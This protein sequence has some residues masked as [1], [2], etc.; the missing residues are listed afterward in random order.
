MFIFYLY[1]MT[2]FRHSVLWYEI[3]QC[4]LFY[5][6]VCATPNPAPNILSFLL[7]RKAWAGV[8]GV[9]LRWARRAGQHYDDSVSNLW[10]VRSKNIHWIRKKNNADPK[11]S[12][13]STLNSWTRYRSDNTSSF[14]VS[15]SDCSLFVIS[16]S[17][18]RHCEKSLILEQSRTTL[19][20]PSYWAKRNIPNKAC[21]R[22]FG[23]RPLN[24]IYN[25]DRLERDSSPTALNDFKNKSLLK[26]IAYSFFFAR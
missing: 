14:A 21:M 7:R 22:F 13:N 25:N 26:I 15:L 23:L 10:F 18:I 12:L 8:V 1:G 24:D 2:V 20:I 17:L 5:I 3:C 9:G 19:I 4:W 11:Q 16:V 6:G